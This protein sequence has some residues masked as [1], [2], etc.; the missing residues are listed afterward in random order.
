MQCMLIFE[1]VIQNQTINEQYEI[2][3]LLL[4]VAVLGVDAIKNNLRMAW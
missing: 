4:Q 1:A 2:T 3:V